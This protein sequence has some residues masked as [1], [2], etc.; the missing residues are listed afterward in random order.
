MEFSFLLEWKQAAVGLSK[1]VPQGNGASDNKA[2]DGLQGAS[3]GKL[4]FIGVR[5]IHPNTRFAFYKYH[6]KTRTEMDQNGQVRHSCVG[7]FSRDWWTVLW[8]SD[9]A[10]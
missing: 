9:I 6:S 2:N 3:K 5:P 8:R 4:W 1:I 7:G 10:E